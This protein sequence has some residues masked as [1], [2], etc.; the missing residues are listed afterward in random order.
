MG[1]INELTVVVREMFNWRVTLDI[2]LIGTALFL[3]YRTL[4]RLGT[5]RILAGLLIAIVLFV[6]AR[7]LDLRGIVWIYS[8][9]SQVAVVAL[10]V[11]FQPELRKMFERFASFARKRTSSVGQDLSNMVSDAVFGLAQQRR[12]AILVFPGKE[13]IT[14]WMS[15]GII[16][17]GDPSSSLIMSIFDPHSPGHDGALI[18]KSGKLSSFGVRLPLSK[19]RTLSE[20]YGTRHHA[21]MGLS[22]VSDAFVVAVSEERGVVSAFHDGRMR[23]VQEK[24]A[25]NSRIVTHWQNT[26]SYPFL[27]LREGKKRTL[28]SELGLSL[29]L[30]FLFWFSVIFAQTEMVERVFSVPVEYVATPSNVALVGNK[31]TEVKLHLSGPKSDLDVASL[32]HP[33]VRIDLSKVE[34]GE[35]EFV[36]TDK[37]L[38]LPRNVKLLDAEPSAFVLTFGKIQEREVPVKP[39][40][41]GKPPH[42]LGIIAVEVNPKTVYIL[43]PEDENEKKEMTL[44]TTPIYL[45]S[46]RESTKL[47]CKIIAPPNAQPAGKRWPDV[48]VTI[49]VEYRKDGM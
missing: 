49:T 24:N 6:T 12:G 18:I 11:I 14:E 15:G 19:R 10:I 1:M 20:E 34:P 41:V 7:M 16:L 9:L 3:I 30:A 13:P 28:V 31:P 17:N 48:E 43:S 4:R 44:M 47:F 27:A 33:A 35:Q 8:N 45:D 23:R 5:W 22:E 37:D 42:G 32:S 39:Q 25:L 26:A 36:V 40:F 21:A 46:I 29:V 38:S 2:L